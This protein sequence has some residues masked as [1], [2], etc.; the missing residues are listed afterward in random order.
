MCF[1]NVKPEI[2]T[3]NLEKLAEE[4][5]GEYLM[6]NSGITFLSRAESGEI[7]LLLNS[8]EE[9]L[10]RTL[11]LE[12]S[13]D[14]R[15]IN[16]TYESYEMVFSDDNVLIKVGQ[17]NN[18]KLFSF[19][20]NDKLMDKVRNVE[21]SIHLKGFGL[22]DLKG[23]WA[24]EPYISSFF[25]EDLDLNE[26]L[27]ETSFLDSSEKEKALESI[28]NCHGGG[29]GSISC[30]AKGLGWECSVTCSPGYYSCCNAMKCKCISLNN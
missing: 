30:S 14:K 15:Q 7:Y 27:V 5:K 22:A 26:L 16:E 9:E 24:S 20:L 18:A 28:I 17:N 1:S 23:E 4:V 3:L 12:M 25:N 21:L 29:P 13:S 11:V 8:N 2:E 10:R 6:S 19:G